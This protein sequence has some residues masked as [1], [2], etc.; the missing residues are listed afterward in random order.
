MQNYYRICRTLLLVIICS[1]CLQGQVN[2]IPFDSDWKYYDLGEEPSGPWQNENYMDASWANG[3]A[4]LGYGDGDENTVIGDTTLTGYFRHVFNVSDPS[5]YTDI[6]LTLLYDDG[7]VV[8]LNGTEIWRVNMP[9]G[10][11]TYNTF[12]SA[13]SGDNVIANLNWANDLVIGDNVIAV[14][15]HQ[16]A[17]GSSDLSFNFELDGNLPGAAVVTRGPYLQ[18]ASETSVTVKWRTDDAVS[19]LVDFGTDL[20]NLN[21]SASDATLTTEHEVTITGLTANTVYYYQIGDLDNVQVPGHAEQYFKTHPVIGTATDTIKAWVLGDCGTANAN[22]R[23]V[24]DAYYDYIGTNHTDVMLFLGDNAYADG[25]DD[26]YQYA[27]FENMYEDKL[28][29]TI[30]WSCLGNHDGHSADS[31]TQTGPYYDIFSFPTNGESGGMASGTEA[32]YSFDYGNVHFICLDSYESPRTVGGTMY[33]WLES[34]L[35]NTMQEWIVAYWHHPPYTKGSHNSD[36]E[37]QLVQMRENFLPLLESYGVDLVL[38]G[39]SHSYERS[40]FINGHYDISDTFDPAINTVG[41]TGA[42]NG[43]VDGDGAYEKN[44]DC[45]NGATYITAGSSGKKSS[46]KP[47]DHEAMYYSVEELGSCILEI[48]DS[49]MNVKFLRE[50]GVIEDYFT[51]VK[52]TSC[53]GPTDLTPILNID[54]TNVTGVSNA[55]FVVEINELLGESTSG[56]ITVSVSRSVNLGLNYDAA[57]SSLSGF[58]LNNA[59]WSYDATNPDYHIFKSTNPIAGNGTSAFGFVGTYDP[60]NK[61]GIDV[62]TVNVVSESGLDSVS[63]NNAHSVQVNYVH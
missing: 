62:F 12:A 37:S 58:A 34:D 27:I 45:S 46:G 26:Q 6:N 22:Q 59:A 55:N 29:N 33:N 60:T 57:L 41:D 2:I 47:L 44:L 52:Q 39:H 54:V 23:N 1:H 31:Q 63:E 3:N 48:A 7:A 15:V 49:T 43:R 17:A 20:A 9:T 51:I 32:Y 18:K 21:L 42:G 13:N 36:T 30:A 8:Y 25:T 19:S 5:I 4:Q 53:G 14:E 38:S 50:T 35:Q 28:K 24:R 10:I 40:Y 61:D 16:R 11:I 56:E